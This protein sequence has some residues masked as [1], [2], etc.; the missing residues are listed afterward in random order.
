MLREYAGVYL[1]G[2]FM[3]AADIVP[4]VSGGTIA[5]ITGIY[6]RLIAAISAVDHHVALQLLRGQWRAASA[7]VDGGFLFFLGLGMA[8]SVVSLARLLSRLLQEQP[9]LVWSFFFG[10]IAG[11]AFLLLRQI[12]HWRPAVLS[13]LSC[14][15]IFAA[16]ISVLPAMQPVSG[17]PALFLAGFAAVCAMILPGISGS[18]IL[19]LLGMYAPVLAAVNSVDVLALST[20]VL[21]ALCGLLS[22]A[23]LLNW[24]LQRYHMTIIALLTGFLIGSLLVVWPWKVARDTPAGGLA[25]ETGLLQWPLSPSAFAEMS[26]EPARVI[27]CVLLMLAGAF[28]VWIIERRWGGARP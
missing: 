6:D 26:G 17:Y 10:L 13:A 28:A 19:V 23:R 8:T 9:L 11:S 12:L 24:L 4:G 14:G 2:V 21:G 5:F 16:G 1:R 3:G 20:L 15:I 18:F 25:T 27:P 7:R 22:F